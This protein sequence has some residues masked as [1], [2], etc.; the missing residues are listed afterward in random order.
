MQRSRSVMQR[1]PYG[2]ATRSALGFALSRM[3]V[4]ALFGR[5]Q[6]EKAVETTDFSSGP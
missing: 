4:I 3:G 1:L 6:A 2:E 5:F